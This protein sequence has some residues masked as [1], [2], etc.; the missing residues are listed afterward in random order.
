MQ[1]PLNEV[2]NYLYNMLGYNL[3]Q[4]CIIWTALRS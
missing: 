1:I 4:M 3:L 2:R